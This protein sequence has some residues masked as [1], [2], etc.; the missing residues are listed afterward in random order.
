MC[1]VVWMLPIL[2]LSLFWVLDVSVALPAYMGVLALSGMVM[3]LTVQS[4]RKPANSGEGD[5]SI[6]RGNGTRRA[7]L[8]ILRIAG[9]VGHQHPGQ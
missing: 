9:D 6:D 4:L 5:A 7:R 1:H 8:I 3:V 2:G